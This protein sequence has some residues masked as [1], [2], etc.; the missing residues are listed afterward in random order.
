MPWDDLQTSNPLNADPS[1]CAVQDVGLR[2]LGCW[3]RGGSNPDRGMDVCFSCL[4]VVLSCNG[5]ITRPEESYRVSN[6]MCDHRNPERGPTFQ[7][8][9]ERRINE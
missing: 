9:N 1:G 3:S 4:Y 5:L 8:G 2:P 6:C 7:V